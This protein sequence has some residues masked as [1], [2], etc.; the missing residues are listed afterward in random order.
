MTCTKP[1][2]APLLLYIVLDDFKKT[3]NQMDLKISHEALMY[4]CNIIA[5]V[6]KSRDMKSNEPLPK[7]FRTRLPKQAMVLL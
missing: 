7:L 3:K 4:K 5:H 2:Q 6:S 1:D